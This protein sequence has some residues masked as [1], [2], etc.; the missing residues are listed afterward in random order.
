MD[1]TV[2]SSLSDRWNVTDLLERSVCS[3]ARDAADQFWIV[4]IAAG[5]QRMHDVRRGPFDA[6]EEAMDAIEKAL[7]GSC[8]HGPALAP[9]APLKGLGERQ[10]ATMSLYR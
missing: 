5:L 1:T 9:A 2:R 10:T 3:I 4:Q 8:R 6:V 7:H